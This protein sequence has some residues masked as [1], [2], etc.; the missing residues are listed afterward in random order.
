MVG[1]C[2]IG[3]TDAVTGMTRFTFKSPNLLGGISLLPALIGLFAVS[4]AFCD[5]ETMGTKI[6]ILVEKGLKG[7]FPSLK[8]MFESWRIL[9]SSSVIGTLV[10]ILPGAGG[11]IASFVAYDQAKRMSKTPEEFGTGC[12]D[13]V[14]ASET[15]NNAVTGGALVP[16]L[17]LGIPGDSTTAVMLGGLLFTDYVQDHYSLR[18]LQRLSMGFS[19]L[20]FSQ[21]VYV[22][23]PVFWYQ[24]ICPY[25]ESTAVP[26]YPFG[27]DPVCYRFLCYRWRRF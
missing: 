10:G 6:E 25:F 16:L 23:F 21:P 5:A 8:R 4:Q 18:R 9:L 24:S 26:S 7:Q 13:G 1:F 12:L 15:S 11:S 3:G 19:L 20:F 17:T 14:I 22:N 27:F 2:F